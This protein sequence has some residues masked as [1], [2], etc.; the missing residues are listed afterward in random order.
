MASNIVKYLIQSRV[1]ENA[2]VINNELPLLIPNLFYYKNS[3]FSNYLDSVVS[4]NNL[5]NNNASCFISISSVPLYDSH[6]HNVIG[7]VVFNDVVT[8]ISNNNIPTVCERI[9]FNFIGDTS[10]IAD[11]SFMSN[12]LSYPTN[13]VSYKIV[14]GSGLFLNL[15]AY[16]ANIN[17]SQDGIR[18]V[19][20][21][22][23]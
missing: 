1:I 10:L 6:T 9:T 20:I 8:K 21:I 5:N 16:H 7:H 19:K 22:H 13:N 12:D 4:A 2:S 23:N 17:I 18:H 15:H 3:D 11:Y 14:A